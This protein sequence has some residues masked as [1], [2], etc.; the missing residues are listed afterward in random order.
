MPPRR[1]GKLLQAV[2]EQRAA[3][4]GAGEGREQ[5]E[6]VD[7]RVVVGLPVSLPVSRGASGA[8]W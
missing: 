7:L 5:A 6:P 1:P 3:L 4:R 2:L 8:M